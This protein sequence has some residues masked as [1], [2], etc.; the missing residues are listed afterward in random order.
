LESLANFVK[1]NAAIK[2]NMNTDGMMEAIAM[3]ESMKAQ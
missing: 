3:R 1:A 2:F